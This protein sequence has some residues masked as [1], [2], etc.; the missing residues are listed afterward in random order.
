[1]QSINKQRMAVM[2]KFIHY[3]IERNV[4][5]YTK[6][7]TGGSIAQSIL[8]EVENDSDTRMILVRW[9][10]HHISHSLSEDAV[11][12]I[13]LG[14]KTNVGVLADHGLQKIHTIMVPVGSGVHCRLAIQLASKIASQENAQVDYVR[15]LPASKNVEI[16]E[17]QMANLQEVVIT[18]LGELPANA[19]LRL[20][21]S[22]QV[23]KALL[24]EVKENPYSLIII[25]SADENG[26]NG[27]MFGKV[28]DQV[29]EKAPCSV[30]VVKRHQSAA[31]SWLRHQVK[32]LDF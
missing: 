22:D 28:A 6:M 17:D 8:K 3:A 30:L 15:V 19:V 23:D 5:M 13:S 14:A 29:A 4:P 11:R 7:V 24:D 9:P 20:L 25:G 2:E 32:R 1:M 10:E 31:A 26:M 27:S 18:E 12:Q 21:F 16:L